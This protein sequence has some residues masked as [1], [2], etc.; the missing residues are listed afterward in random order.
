MVGLLDF[1]T[2]GDPEQMAQ[3]DPRYGVPRSD[4]R[5]AAVN[6]LG[7]ISALL[8]AAGQPITPAQRAQLIAQIGPAAAGAGTDLY[9]AAQR[10]LMTAQMQQR[11]AQQQSATEFA[12]ML[13]GRP[14]AGTAAGAA[15]GAA[16]P[17]AG[18]PSGGAGAAAPAGAAG[19][20]PPAR[21]SARTIENMPADLRATAA[22]AALSGD[23]SGA[24]QIV[25]NWLTPP[26]PDEFSRLL[27]QAGV[28]P[29]SPEARTLARNIL[30]NRGTP[31]P[32]QMGPIP[33]GFRAIYDERGRPVGMEP[34]PGSPAAREAERAEQAGRVRTEA[35]QQTGGTVIRSI[36]RA[37]EI[38]RTSVLPTTGFFAD[39][40]AGRGGTGARDLRGNLDTIRANIGFDQLNQM[41][42]ASP[43]GGALGNV[44]NQEIAYLQA[45]MGSVDQ[46]QSEGELRRNLRRLREAYD[47]IVNYGLG[48]RP[49]VQIPG[50]GGRG[51]AEPPRPAEPAAR[52]PG[53][54]TPRPGAETQ[55]PGEIRTQSGIIIRPIQ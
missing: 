53:A 10:R 41:R 25:A 13:M 36:D 11:Q 46:S 26:Q 49:P 3:I 22:R 44:S 27:A 8:L 39:F 15:A 43:T 37:E 9:N 33:P 52:R 14:A 19:G 51:T 4:V 28:E 34:I 6:T 18:E 55:R 20:Q 12:N 31:P 21:G 29:D 7:N 2:G 24:R 48:N 32:A 45:V 38:M 50:P 1:F 42:Q 54:E 17:A 47:E 16:A 23:L 35:A 30:E 5:D 40:L